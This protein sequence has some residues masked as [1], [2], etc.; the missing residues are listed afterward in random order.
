MSCRDSSLALLPLVPIDAGQSA[1]RTDGYGESGGTTMILREPNGVL[2]A[3]A[4][5]AALAAAAPAHAEDDAVT[6]YGRV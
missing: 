1:G 4:T 2:L 3:M 6:L 5:A